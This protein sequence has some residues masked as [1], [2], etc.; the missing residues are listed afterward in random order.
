MP[1]TAGRRIRA[2]GG[3]GDGGMRV[4]LWWTHRDFPGEALAGSGPWTVVVIDCLR[5]TTSIAAALWAGCTAV[6]AVACEPRAREM[7]SA[8]GAVLAGEQDCV[9]PPGFD[10]GNSPREVTPAA[11]RGREVVLWTTNGTQ[12][13]AAAQAVG[14]DLVAA[15]LVNATAVARHLRAQRR[16]QLAILCAGTEGCFSLEDAF[17][18]GAL[19]HRLVEPG[20]E[21]VKLDERA[22]AALLLYRGGRV[23]ARAVLDGTVAASKLRRHGLGADVGF[24]AQEDVLPVVPRWMAGALRPAP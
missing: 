18:A 19:L 22:T 1:S 24:A 9:P 11:V 16:G 7:A 8:H 14:G 5:A 4:H 2:E 20:D 10:L 6:R 12:A 17:A 21:T 3:G 15:A 23:D 13:L